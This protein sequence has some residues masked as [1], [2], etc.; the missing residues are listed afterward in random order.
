MT[1]PYE[2]VRGV[3]PEKR[4]YLCGYLHGV[5]DG[6]TLQGLN[7]EDSVIEFPIHV[8]VPVDTLP[9]TIHLLSHRIALLSRAATRSRKFKCRGRGM[10]IGASDLPVDRN[11]NRLRQ[12][13]PLVGRTVNKL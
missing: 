13:M 8:I 12:M 10:F 4:T 3:D 9:L 7:V 1:Q 11:F 6:Q 5:I 2:D